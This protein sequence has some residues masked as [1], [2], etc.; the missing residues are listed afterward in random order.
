[1]SESREGVTEG[2]TD[3]VREGGMERERDVYITCFLFHPIFT[4]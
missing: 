2:V 3:G 1:V 4:L